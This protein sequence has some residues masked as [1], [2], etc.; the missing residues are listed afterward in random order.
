MDFVFIDLK[1]T[2]DWLVFICIP[3]VYVV[4]VKNNTHDKEHFPLQSGYSI[5]GFVCKV[6]ESGK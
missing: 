3:V 4:D 2:V 6:F 1:G 5:F